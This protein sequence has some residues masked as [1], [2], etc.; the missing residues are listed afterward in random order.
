[1]LILNQK[2]V[3]LRSG[4]S[5]AAKFVK[6]RIE[7]LRENISEDGKHVVFE[8]CDHLAHIAKIKREG[9]EF[10]TRRVF[11]NMM[12]IEMVA[13]VEGEDGMEEWAYTKRALKSYDF[14]DFDK[15]KYSYPRFEFKGRLVVDLD[16]TP[17]FAYFM[18]YC[19]PHCLG[20][21]NQGKSIIFK[22]VNRKQDAARKLELRRIKSKAEQLIT[23]KYEE[24]GL[25]RKDVEKYAKSLFM[26]NASDMH[27]DILREEVWEKVEKE[28]LYADVLK[29]IK[30]DDRE[31]C[32]VLAMECI[33]WNVI[34]L[35]DS[36]GK[37]E[38]RFLG[39]EGRPGEIITEIPVK[40]NA[41]HLLSDKLFKFGKI[42]SEAEVSLDIAKETKPEEE[43][44]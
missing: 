3:D 30:A 32:N 6:K 41:I 7:F 34:K 13:S 1:M 5:K 39:E 33:E 18:Y 14:G 28:N 44:D 12:N 15:T 21:E 26:H 11:P 37:K 40:S 16:K 38:W 43:Q 25:S 20:G 27:E 8:Y 36:R 31:A 9:G 2:Q 35:F 23:F 4:T 42:R 29:E 19:S 22:P 10:Y 24:G 17:D